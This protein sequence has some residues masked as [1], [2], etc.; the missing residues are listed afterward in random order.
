M[1][2]PVITMTWEAGT[3]ELVPL[4]FFRAAVAAAFGLGVFLATAI[5]VLVLVLW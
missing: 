5:F 2:I 3:E 1:H 4:W